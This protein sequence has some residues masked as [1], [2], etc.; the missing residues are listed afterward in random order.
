MQLELII[1]HANLKNLEGKPDP[2]HNQQARSAVADKEDFA[3]TKRLTQNGNEKNAPRLDQA[4]TRRQSSQKR[5]KHNER[6]ASQ[7]TEWNVPKI[8]LSQLTKKA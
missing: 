3:T 5:P 6:K 2:E 7:K 4:E 8:S 1:H